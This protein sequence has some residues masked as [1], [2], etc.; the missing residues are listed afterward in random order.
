MIELAEGLSK[1]S[2][3]PQLMLWVAWI[4]IMADD[5]IAD[6]EALLI[7]HLVRLVRDHH[8]VVD[9][10]L[11]HLVDIDPTE[12]WQRIDAEPGDLS[13]I[14]D[15]ADRVATADGAVNASEK[16]VISELRD[17]CLRACLTPS[18]ATSHN[19]QGSSSPLG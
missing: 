15:A 4:V 11:A 13:D 18:R 9:E 17:R 19:G 3:H 10:Q 5:K 14:L 6:D 16:A 12:V 1:R 7:R 2:R 8:Q